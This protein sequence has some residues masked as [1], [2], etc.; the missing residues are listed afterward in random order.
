[1]S[2]YQKISVLG[3]GNWG[4]A[5]ANHLAQAG[6]LVTG[7]SIESDIVESINKN[8]INCRY[9]SGT[10]LS[11]NLRAT[12]ELVEA[13]DNQIIVLVVPSDALSDVLPRVNLEEGSLLV[14]AVKGLEKSSLK[15]PL[16][17]ARQV[18]GDK[19]KLS[20]LSGPSFA[21]DVVAGKPCGVV[22]ASEHEEDAR[23]TANIFSHG[24]MRVY[25][26]TDPLGVELGGILKNVIALAA[27]ISDGM[28]L[29]DS[30]RAGL[31]TRGL[32]EIT[33][34]AVAMGANEKTLSG[35]SGLGDLVMTASCDTSRNRTVGLRLGRGEKLQ[36]IID[37]L[38]S[39]AEG[40]KTAPLVMQ[41]AENYG[42]EMPITFEMSRVL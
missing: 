18:L 4:T 40:V 12:S 1:M 29:G 14:S 39:V 27:G 32:A 34:L 36:K 8:H 26:S 28:G 20:V 24:N 25:I 19:V 33:R 17:Y 15:T 38:G 23:L 11:S 13:L 3:L 9:Q 6:Y 31:I 30:A 5:L 21:V 7:W 35:L 16:Q 41:L 37:T 10:T 42:V 2:K 22:A